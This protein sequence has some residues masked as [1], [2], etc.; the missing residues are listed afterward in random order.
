MDSKLVLSTVEKLDK[1]EAPLRSEIEVRILKELC[2][3]TGK[4]DIYMTWVKGYKKIKGNEEAD[5]LCREALILGHK[6]WEVV[7]PASLRAYSKG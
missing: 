2:K 6:S 5:K 3:R 1:G 4:K 7:T